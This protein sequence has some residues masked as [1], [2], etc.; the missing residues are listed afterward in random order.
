M[1]YKAISDNLKSKIFF[2]PPWLG[3]I[4]R[5]MPDSNN[6]HY[7][8]PGGVMCIRI[9]HTMIA[10]VFIILVFYFLPYE[11]E[12]KLFVVTLFFS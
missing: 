8:I 10:V 2:V 11:I 6:F 4:K 1:R 9:H 3:M 5:K 12:C 7:S